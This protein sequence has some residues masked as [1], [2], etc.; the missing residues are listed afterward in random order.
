MAREGA[1]SGAGGKAVG[2][3]FSLLFAAAGTVVAADR[4]VLGVPLL[5]AKA[6]GA[7]DAFV[8]AAGVAAGAAVGAAMA[9]GWS[10][11]GRLGTVMAAGWPP[12][13]RSCR[14]G[15]TGFGRGETSAVRGSVAGAVVGELPEA[16]KPPTSPTA[17]GSTER[18][19][20]L[21]TGAAK[22]ASEGAGAVGANATASA[23]AGETG[24]DAA[25]ATNGF[26]G[27]AAGVT[28]GPAFAGA[29]AS[30][31]ALAGAVKAAAIWE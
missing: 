10:G 26:F 12:V 7:V 20:G 23:S 6:V 29:G 13:S 31:L 5:E 19:A 9:R 18:E 27:A 3:D 24:P 8:I 16:V 1:E 17:G 30:A 25:G 28:A 14:P 21:G 15:L 4:P 22:L 11:S 2:A